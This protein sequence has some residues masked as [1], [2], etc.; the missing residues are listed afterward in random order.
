MSRKMTRSR[1][2][3]QHNSGNAGLHKKKFQT[4]SFVRNAWS[5]IYFGGLSQLFAINIVQQ[6]RTFKALLQYYSPLCCLALCL[7]FST[8]TNSQL[9]FVA[10]AVGGLPLSHAPVLFANTQLSQPVNRRFKKKRVS[11]DPA[12]NKGHCFRSMALKRTDMAVIFQQVFS[13]WSCY[14]FCSLLQI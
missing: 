13:G 9:L 11:N 3:W 4:V 5:C 8:A 6:C 7:L 2:I 10:G 1:A 14:L 12:L